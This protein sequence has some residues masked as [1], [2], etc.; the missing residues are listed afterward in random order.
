LPV[1]TGYFLQL[2][3]R[4]NGQIDILERTV[5]DRIKLRAG[6]SF[7]KTVPGIGQILALTIMLETG[8]IRRFSTVGDY[9]SYCRCVGSQKLSN[10]K[11]KGSG[12]TKNGKQ[13]FGLGVCR[14]GQLRDPIQCEDQKLLSEKEGQE[15]RCI[16]DQSGGAQA[17]SGLLLHHERPGALRYH[18]GF[19]LTEKFNGWDGA[20]SSRRGWFKSTRYD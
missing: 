3:P 4:S 15:P 1:K 9:A 12:N 10:G 13:V 2:I 17:V 8:E 5:I 14:S 7:L 16:G 19:C 18:Q 20:V 6:F 11:K